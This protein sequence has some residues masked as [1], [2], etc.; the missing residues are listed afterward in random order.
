MSRSKCTH[1]VLINNVRT[2]N[3]AGYT[4]ATTVLNELFD[5]CKANF[6]KSL[7][8]SIWGGDSAAEDWK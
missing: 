5:E 7:I 6:A 1:A 4:E 8:R 2:A 3:M